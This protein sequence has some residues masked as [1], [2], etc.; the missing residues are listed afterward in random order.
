MPRLII[1]LMMVASLAILTLQNLADDSAVPLVVL[2]K[3]V[4]NE[5]PLGFLLLLSVAAGA[6]I[7]LILHGLVG[8]LRPPESKYRPMGRRVPYP[9]SPG[10]TTLPP[11]GPST[12]FSPVDSSPSRY[13]SSSA[14]VSEPSNPSDAKPQAQPKKVE[15]TSPGRAPFITPPQDTQ[16]KSSSSSPSLAYRSAPAYNDDFAEPPNSYFQPRDSATSSQRRDQRGDQRSEQGRS[17]N[18]NFVQQPMAGLKSVIGNFGKKKDHSPEKS[19]PSVN[20]DRRPG[21]D[22]GDLRTTEQR[23]SW[24]VE[25][26]DALNLEEGAK[27][28]FNFGRDV[29]ANAGRLAEDIAS[30]WTRSQ[31]EGRDGQGG[32]TSQSANP[33]YSE[34]Y[35][36]E[37][38]AANRD[39]SL[40]QGWEN[41]DDYS[42]PPYDAPVKRTYGESLYGEDSD[43]SPSEMGPDG[44]YE[45]DYRVI[46]PPSGPLVDPLVDPDEDDDGYRS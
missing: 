4:A 39:N 33:D 19:T 41:F 3:T 11:S 30:G 15:P 44:V 17:S 32:G 18:G 24:D 29:G 45:A 5:M 27:N 25:G 46:V 12:D 35:A 9:D 42:E 38:Y 22:W 16:P 10:S 26:R 34:G 40:D 6:L 43:E 13:G 21:D 23:N 1:L 2:G 7:T 31:G 28:L 36:P 14:F 20:A 8:L 37:G